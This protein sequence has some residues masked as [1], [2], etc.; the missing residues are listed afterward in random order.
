MITAK[1]CHVLRWEPRRSAQFTRG[2]IGRDGGQPA[3]AE[4]QAPCLSFVEASQKARASTLCTTRR[5]AMRDHIVAVG[6][7]LCQDGQG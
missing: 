4:R 6:V 2:R 5:A 3:G 1:A 7:T